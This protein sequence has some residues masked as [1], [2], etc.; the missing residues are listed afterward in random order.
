[1]GAADFDFARGEALRFDAFFAGPLVAFAGNA[2]AFLRAA[3][4]LGF[5]DLADLRAFTGAFFNLL[6][7]PPV[8]ISQT[9]C[10]YRAT[11]DDSTSQLSEDYLIPIRS[12]EPSEISSLSVFRRTAAAASR[13]KILKIGPSFQE[14][15]IHPR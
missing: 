9:P 5:L 15:R 6:R 8:A 4:F 2:L 13:F 14:R 7:V 3:A 1:M 10:K 11:Y 12:C